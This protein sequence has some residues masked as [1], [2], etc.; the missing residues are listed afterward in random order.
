MLARNAF[1]IAPIILNNSSTPKFN[2][3]N[4]FFQPYQKDKLLCTF[5]NYS[6]RLT[7][8][9]CSNYSNEYRVVIKG[10]I[11][12]TKYGTLVKIKARPLHLNIF[13]LIFFAVPLSI[14]I[15]ST[16]QDKHYIQSIVCSI[17]LSAMYIF[18]Y[19]LFKYESIRT[20]QVFSRLLTTEK[21]FLNSSPDNKP[22]YTK[23]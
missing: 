22:A 16:L 18:N 17:I 23:P 8:L 7:H 20:I 21:N 2:I 6:F 4:F 1:W 14:G 12:E 10:D 3:K 15:I 9:K 13:I 5:N 11:I 19:A